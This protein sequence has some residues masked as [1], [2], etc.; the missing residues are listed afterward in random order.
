MNALIIIINLFILET[1]LSIDNAAVLSILVIKLPKQEQPKALKYGILGAFA[2]RGLCLF[3]AAWLVK[4]TWLKIT[5][6]LYLI[7]LAYQHFSKKDNDDQQSTTVPKIFGLNPFWS[8]VIMVEIADLAFSLDNVFAAVALTSDIWLII[9]GVFL[10][11]I[12]MRFVAQKFTTLIN[13]YPVLINSAFIV[14]LCLGLKLIASCIYIHLNSHAFDLLF[15][16]GM[17]VIFFA[18]LFFKKNYQK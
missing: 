6:G 7:W 5:G 13:K 14:I 15:S 18:P 10:G 8:T 12:S 1:L 17:M 3:I 11:I 4:I 16:L 2:F 9:T